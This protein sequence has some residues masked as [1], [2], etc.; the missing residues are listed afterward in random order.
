MRYYPSTLNPQP[1]PL[2]PWSPSIHIVQLGDATTTPVDNSAP[3]VA[4]SPPDSQIDM[5]GAPRI[6]LDDL[7]SLDHDVMCQATSHQRPPLHPADVIV[8]ATCGCQRRA[9]CWRT[10]DA[11]MTRNA[12]RSSPSGHVHE[13]HLTETQLLDIIAEAAHTLALR[14]AARLRYE[15]S[16]LTAKTLDAEDS[17]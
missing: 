5:D 2:G 3:S 6:S 16:V 7:P 15:R 10:Y 14:Q 17:A 4:P 12:G 8:G 13:I 11:D 1:S 9:V